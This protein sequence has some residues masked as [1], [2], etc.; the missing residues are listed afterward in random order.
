MEEGDEEAGL[1]AR[2]KKGKVGERWLQVES[3]E[4]T[5]DAQNNHQSALLWFYCVLNSTSPTLLPADF[6]CVT[7]C[8][9]RG[10]LVY[11]PKDI[12]NFMIV[13][14][15]SF[16]SNIKDQPLIRSIDAPTVFILSSQNEWP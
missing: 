11:F 12:F 4:T 5:E 7:R 15:P 8:I 1:A 2:K 10:E 9:L 13:L 14:F 6:S 3:S 16:H